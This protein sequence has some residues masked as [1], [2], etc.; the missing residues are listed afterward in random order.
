MIEE[1]PA[2]LGVPDEL[3]D[4]NEINRVLSSAWD[5]AEE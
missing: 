3:L 1:E 4:D 5:A 2:E